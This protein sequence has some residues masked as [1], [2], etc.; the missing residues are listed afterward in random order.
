MNNF[1]KQ[2]GILKKGKNG[3]NEYVDFIGNKYIRNEKTGEWIKDGK[4]LNEQLL[5][6]NVLSTLSFSFSADASGGGSIANRFFIGP[7][8]YGSKTVSNWLKDVLNGSDS[9][10]FLVVGDSN[11]GYGGQDANGGY[12]QGLGYALNTN[13]PNKMYSTAFLSSLSSGTVA[14][15]KTQN[16]PGNFNL[17][18]YGYSGGVEHGPSELTSNFNAYKNAAEYEDGT[19]GIFS[20]TGGGAGGTLNYAFLKAGSSQTNVD[21]GLYINGDSPIGTGNTLTYRVL[22]G[23][24]PNTGGTYNVRIRHSISPYTVVKTQTDISV[25][26]SEY[27][28]MADSITITGDSSRSGMTL[29]FLWSIQSAAGILNVGPVAIAGQSVHA[30]RKGWSV[31]SLY[32]SGGSSIER[33]LYGFNMAGKETVATLLKEYRDKQIQAGGSGRVVILIQGGINEYD[34]TGSN[35]SQWLSYWQSII[36]KCKEA[37]ATINVPSS[38][39]QFCVMFSHNDQPGVSTDSDFT[40]RRNLLIS[41]FKNNPEVCVIHLPSIVTF[42]VGNFANGGSYYVDNAHLTKSGFEFVSDQIIK[43][44]LST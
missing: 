5:V 31:D 19:N 15:Y 16:F 10:D 8:L 3:L 35:Q 12:V 13:I 41:L 29:D 2:F 20:D 42:G 6:N 14:A 26:G 34:W 17:P 36:T 18:T 30:N 23:S 44:M 9:I 39:L 40:E 37:W 28:W 22:R 24:I 1:L 7:K 33:Y 11:T 25:R 4:S 32:F 27:N 38:D 43:T 21:I